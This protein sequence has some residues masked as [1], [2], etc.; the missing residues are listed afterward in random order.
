MVG[1]LR[2]LNI[3]I[4]LKM[5]STSLYDPGIFTPEGRNENF[6][7]L[8]SDGRGINNENYRSIPASL[9]SL[10]CLA[11]AVHILSSGTFL[12][13]NLP[14]PISSISFIPA[15][16]YPKLETVTIAGYAVWKAVVLPCALCVLS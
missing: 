1:H 5:H 4:V 6:N 3:S 14:V 9:Q 7:D 2:L 11:D 12:G 16:R 8:V 15:T 13:R 10:L